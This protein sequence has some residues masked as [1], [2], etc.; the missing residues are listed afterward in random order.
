MVNVSHI[1][2]FILEEGGGHSFY[3]IM[4]AWNLMRF[5]VS[6]RQEMRSNAI[7]RLRLN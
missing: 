6:N 7:S 5:L 1:R 2:T 4:G 3:F